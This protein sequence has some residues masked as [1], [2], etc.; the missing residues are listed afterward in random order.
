M[1]NR[2]EKGLN[3][4]S[5]MVGK[6]IMDQTIEHVKQFNPDIAKLIVEFAFG[7][8]Y[9][10]PTLDLKQKEL[11][12]ISS[13]VSQGAESQL[14]FHIHAAL[15]IGLTPKEIV[16]AIIHCIPYIGFPRS[17][18]ALKVVIEVFNSRNIKM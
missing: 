5:K 12:T 11:L 13:L 8:I 14:D 9:S 15:N 10:R 1:T 16:E 17:L 7:D 3:T 6:D 2:Y 4:L 18:G